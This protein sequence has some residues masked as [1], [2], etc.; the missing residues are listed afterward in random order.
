M[1]ETLLLSAAFAFASA[2]VFTVVGRAVVDR[3]VSEGAQR[4]LR[5]FST[6]WYALALTT[7]LGG[8]QD[9]LGYA[10]LTSLALFTSLTYLNLL[11]ICVALLGLLYYLLYLFTGKGWLLEP[12]V[13]VYIVYYGWLVYLI[14]AADPIA[15]EVSAWSTTLEYANP[16][17]GGPESLALLLLVGPQII[18]ALAYFTTFFRLEDPRQRYRVAVVSWSI[19]VW[20]GTSL[21]GS[22]SGL[23]EAGWWQLASRLIS[24]L[25]ALAIYSA[26][27]PPAWLERR[28]RPSG[29]ARGTS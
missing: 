6:W 25:A 22:A 9:I 16:I 21:I 26:Y 29:T 20:F 17:Q 7:A 12:L 11:L 4:A 14:T 27:R 18:G 15:V 28:W 24:L 8:A 23:A 5:F 3:E 2:G 13:A 10:G 19:I 1:A